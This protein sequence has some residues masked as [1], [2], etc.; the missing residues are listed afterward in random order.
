MSDVTTEQCTRVRALTLTLAI[1]VLLLVTS[2]AG[3]QGRVHERALDAFEASEDAYARGDLAEAARL[4]REAYALEPTP[5]LLYNLGRV[6]ERLDD[7]VCALDAYRAYLDVVEDASDRA[8]VEARIAALTPPPPTA[9]AVTTPAPPPPPGSD[10]VPGAILTAGGCALVLSAVAMA[11]ATVLIDD[12][13]RALTTPLGEAVDAVH[14]RDALTI[15][16]PITLVAGLLVAALGGGWLGI[17]L[18]RPSG[19]LAWN[20][21]ALRF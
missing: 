10:V 12:H 7:D 14:T 11:I 18:A 21:L 1:A 4:L 13:A 20:D 6:C 16:W 15:A 2:V 5:V 3:A 8:D 19:G 17:E 9:V